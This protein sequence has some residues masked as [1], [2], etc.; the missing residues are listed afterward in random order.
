MNE[1]FVL[2]LMILMFFFTDV[3]E[4]KQ[5]QYMIGY[6]FVAGLVVCICVHLFFLF[7]DIVNQLIDYLKRR[8]AKRETE[9]LKTLTKRRGQRNSKGNILLLCARISAFF[10]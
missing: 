2:F 9:L 10:S 5:D 3:T 6:I 1:V 4:S 8:K 7:K